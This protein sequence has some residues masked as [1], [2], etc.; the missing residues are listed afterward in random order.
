VFHVVRA[1]DSKDVTHVEDTV[2][3][4]RDLETITCKYIPD[5]VVL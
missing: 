2:D 4:E 3:P 1:F 5:D